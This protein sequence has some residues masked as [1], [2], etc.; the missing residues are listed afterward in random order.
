MSLTL[1]SALALARAVLEEG[2]RRGCAPLA[3]VVTDPGGRDICALRG[4]GAGH[5]RIVIARAKAGGALG[6]GFNTRDVQ[7]LAGRIPD[8]VAAA[9][10][11]TEGGLIPSPGGVILYRG[12][13]LAGAIG[14]SGDTGDNDEACILAVLKGSELQA[15]AP[16]WDN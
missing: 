15:A 13:E 16:Y 14:V 7:V 6:I 2:Q 4:D 12:G 1:E 11:A 3:V 5:L 10:A 9:N 8:F